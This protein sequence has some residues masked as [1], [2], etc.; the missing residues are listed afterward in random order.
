[1][2]GDAS[3]IAFALPRV[4]YRIANGAPAN[5]QIGKLQNRTVKLDNFAQRNNSAVLGHAIAEPDELPAVI[6]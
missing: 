6:V 3:S 4:P 2:V 1:M 5:R